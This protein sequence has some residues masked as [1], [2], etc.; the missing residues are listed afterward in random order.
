MLESPL[1][2]AG[3]VSGDE[4]LAAH[5]LMEVLKRAVVTRPAIS[6]ADVVAKVRTCDA[7]T[8]DR[9]GD[10]VDADRKELLQRALAEWARLRS[11]T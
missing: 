7:I 1:A 11:P 6:F 3:V 5:A 10:G 8:R 4:R 9:I 2:A